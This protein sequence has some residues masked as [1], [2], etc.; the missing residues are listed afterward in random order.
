VCL[1]CLIVGGGAPQ[2]VSISSKEWVRFAA[3]RDK[4]EYL[5]LK[6]GRA[7]VPVAAFGAT[8]P[9]GF[10]EQTSGG[11]GPQAEEPAYELSVP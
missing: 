11:P 2:V 6:L 8:G 9:P 1:T 4:A 7:G 10:D 5:A 3:G